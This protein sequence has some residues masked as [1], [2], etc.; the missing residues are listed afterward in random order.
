MQ[1]RRGA[2][3]VDE[4]FDPEA[5]GWSAIREPGPLLLQVLAIPLLVLC[6]GAVAAA[7]H[8]LSP[9][10]LDDMMER[11]GGLGL[12]L[13]IVAIIVVHELIHALAHPGNGR[14]ER[15]VVGVWPSRGLAYAHWIGELSRDRFL[16]VFVAPSLA[17]TVAPL[18]V[19]VACQL[20]WWPLA[21]VSLINAALAAGDAVGVLLVATQI[22]REAMV[23]NKGWRSYYRI[24]GP[25][26]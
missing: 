15:T 6:V 25:A 12:L 17:L 2:P 7:F 10:D 5:E 4:D 20:D 11:L 19:A 18:V 13:A 24:A 21:A 1:L 8:W 26:D 3:P 16:W 23:R 9:I 22:P 14:S